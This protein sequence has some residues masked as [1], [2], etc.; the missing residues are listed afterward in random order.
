MR[1]KILNRCLDLLYPPKCVFCDTLLKDGEVYFCTQCGETVPVAEEEDVFRKGKHFDRCIAPLYYCDMVRDSFLDYKFHE[2]TWRAGTYA[3]LL[4]PYVRSAF[5]S[6]DVVTWIPLS[7]RTL[8]DRGY[9]QAQLIAR[10]LSLR[11]KLPCE[12]ML[13]K[14]R[15]TQQQ[16]RLQSPEE[17]RSNVRNAFSLKRGARVEGRNILLIDDI[18]TTGS[19]MESCS[20]VL[21]RA[22]AAQVHCAAVAQ[23]VGNSR[24]KKNEEPL[25]KDG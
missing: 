16:S 4:E 14:V 2:K 19:T 24:D 18:I 23:A 1:G 25:A 17:R 3:S 6:L 5:P 20:R 11:L 21:E 15:D 9:D 22:G 8:R 7:R 12:A 13:E 10:E